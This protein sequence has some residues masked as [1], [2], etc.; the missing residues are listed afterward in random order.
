MDSLDS[1]QQ[2]FEVY[3]PQAKQPSVSQMDLFNHGWPKYIRLKP[4]T[5]HCWTT[6]WIPDGTDP[7]VYPPSHPDGGTKRPRC[8]FF[9]ACNNHQH[10]SLVSCGSSTVDCCTYGSGTTPWA[11][12]KPFLEPHHL[13]D[14]RPGPGGPPYRNLL[15]VEAPGPTGIGEH[16][17]SDLDTEAECLKYDFAT[18][19]GVSKIYNQE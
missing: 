9:Y 11:C 18:P 16:V 12:N 19:L 6:K 3:Y 2:S 10:E 17:Q 14:D 13:R 8:Q 7:G 5:W 1:E 4:S 15:N